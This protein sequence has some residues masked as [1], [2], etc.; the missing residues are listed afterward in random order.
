MRRDLSTRPSLATTSPSSTHRIAAPSTRSVNLTDGSDRRPLHR[1]RSP[2]VPLGLVAVQQVLHRRGFNQWL[3]FPFHILALCWLGYVSQTARHIL[4][5]IGGWLAV[6]GGAMNAL[7]VA[8]SHGMMPI[9]PA[10]WHSLFA[11]PIMNK[12]RMHIPVLSGWRHFFGDRFPVSHP[13]MVV[14]FGDIIL[15]GGGLTAL[16]G[17]GL[18]FNS[19]RHTSRSTS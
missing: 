18:A 10:V 3:S 7:L 11:G 9:D 5:R 6:A 1:L 2:L 12:E 19:H 13:A 15:F 4:S 16:V 17:V 8:S 14:S